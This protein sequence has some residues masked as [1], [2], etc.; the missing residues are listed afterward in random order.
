MA[1][2]T[3]ISYHRDGD[4]GLEAWPDFAL[5]TIASGTLKQTGHTYL[6]NGVFTSGVWECTSGE[7]IPGDYDVDEMM[8]VLD[9]AITIEHES[10]ASQT[11]TAGQAFVIPKGTPCQWIQTETTRKFWAI[12][13]SPGELNSDFELEAMLLDPEAK[14]PSMGAQDPTVFESA[15]PEMGML[16][17][18]KDPTG[19]FIAGLWEST[20][21]T[22]KPGIIERS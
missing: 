14:L 18:H 4:N 17:L 7:L 3:V 1:D 22:R 15:P 2:L 19:K 11:F 8:I 21:M 20:P 13:D 5:D 9:G 12:Y 6:D 16:I 10:G